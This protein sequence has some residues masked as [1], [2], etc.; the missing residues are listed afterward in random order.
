[1]LIVLTEINENLNVVEERGSCIDSKRNSIIRLTQ[2]SIWYMIIVYRIVAS[3]HLTQVS[4]VVEKLFH[5]PTSSRR[6]KS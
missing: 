4:N 2:A 3:I 6:Y 5:F 1:M